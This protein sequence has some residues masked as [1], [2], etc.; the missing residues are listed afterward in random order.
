M[1]VRLWVVSL[2]VVLVGPLCGCSAA[3]PASPLPGAGIL[4]SGFGDAVDRDLARVIRATAPFH[5]LRNAVA[6]GYPERVTRCL[7]RAPEGAMGFHHQRESLLDAH[8]EVERPEIL[9]YGR[10]GRGEYTLN[11]VEYIVPFSAWTGEQPP[12]ILSHDLK[13]A[14]SLGIWY[15][16]VW[17]WEPN[18]SGLFADWNPAVTC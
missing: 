15:L 3:A 7:D 6:A 10:T 14:P 12:R 17:I 18:P 4:P 5:D 2:A 11:G 8:L 13:P 9:V 16:H 1:R